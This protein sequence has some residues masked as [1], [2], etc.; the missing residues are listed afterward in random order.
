[1]SRIIKWYKQHFRY[2]GEP[3][4]EFEEGDIVKLKINGKKAM[5]VGDNRWTDDHRYPDF[6]IRFEDMST[7][8]VDQ[9]ELEKVKGE[10]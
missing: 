2:K 6:V 1:M 5:I 8:K 10:R 9:Y 4:R 3:R 7:Y